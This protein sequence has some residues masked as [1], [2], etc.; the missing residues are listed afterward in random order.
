MYNVGKCL[1]L[2][3]QG[4]Y[5]DAENYADKSLMLDPNNAFGWV[6]KGMVVKA[7]GN[8]M[9]ESV[10]IKQFGVQTNGKTSI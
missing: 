4:R 6:S 1:I 3:K 5:E 10:I 7:K 8:R 2:S 9:E